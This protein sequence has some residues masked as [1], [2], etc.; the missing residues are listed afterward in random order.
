MGFN[1]ELNRDQRRL[2]QGKAR[3]L[4][5]D[6]PLRARYIDWINELDRLLV[7]HQDE[8]C[9]PVSKSRTPSTK[10]R[11]AETEQ[12]G[13]PAPVGAVS[14]SHNAKPNRLKQVSTQS[15][16]SSSAQVGSVNGCSIGSLACSDKCEQ[17][18]R[19]N[20]ILQQMLARY[21]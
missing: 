12:G 8:S 20:R 13:H 3:D 11:V 16:A 5:S 9:L 2:A 19:E 17:L 7:N 10:A 14:N 15:K 4:P 1:V 6:H 18:L 21:F